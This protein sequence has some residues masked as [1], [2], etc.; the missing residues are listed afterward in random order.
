[1]IWVSLTEKT[2]KYNAAGVKQ[3][4]ATY[5]GPANDFDEVRSLAIDASIIKTCSFTF[6]SDR[7]IFLEKKLL[8]NPILNHKRGKTDHLACFS[9][10]VLSSFCGVPPFIVMIASE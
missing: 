5:N 9:N 3:W 7:F 10:N 4:V 8:L 1:M 6:Y 2:I